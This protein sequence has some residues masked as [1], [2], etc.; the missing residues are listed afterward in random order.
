LKWI[1]D[2][3]NLDTNISRNNIRINVLPKILKKKPNLESYLFEKK[4]SSYNKYNSFKNWINNSAKNLIFESNNNYIIICNTSCKTNN[5]G[6]FKLFYQ[7]ICSMLVE[8]EEDLQKTRSF[9]NSLLLF[10]ENSKTGSLFLL[11][12]YLT[13][14]KG[15]KYHYIYR[16]EFIKPCIVKLKLNNVSNWYNTRFIFNKNLI[17]KKNTL[18]NKFYVSKKNVEKGLLIRNWNYGDRVFSEFYNTDISLKNIFIN[19][20]I[21]C[22][23]KKIYPIITNES[24]EIICVPGLTFNRLDDNIDLIKLY[25]ISN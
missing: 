14:I 4:A 21:S 6:Y 9:W 25:W 18:I 13:I 23:K 11:N 5:N 15:R 12:D 24:N 22:F 1:D 16:N 20:K 19:K 2:K 17:N 3:S 7:N 10:V 8:N